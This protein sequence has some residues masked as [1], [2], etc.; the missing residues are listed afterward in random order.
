MT[1]W[2]Q[3]V[4]KLD[5]RKCL[6]RSYR[7]KE[8][9]GQL[10]KLPTQNHTTE[11]KRKKTSKQPRLNRTPLKLINYQRS[12]PS[13]FTFG[14]LFDERRMLEGLMSLCTTHCSVPLCK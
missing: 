10:S 9:K 12:S 4:F 8:P 14:F 6:S 3:K 5:T 11:R 7:G 13:L 2:D 1:L